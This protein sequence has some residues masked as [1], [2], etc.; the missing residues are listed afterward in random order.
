MHI[1]I[2]K[3]NSKNTGCA[4]SFSYNEEGTVWLNMIQQFSWDEK[5]GNGSFSQNA[6]NKDKSIRLKF[7]EFECGTLIRA[8]D[9]WTEAS[10]Y[11]SFEDTKTQIALTTWERGE[12]KQ[13]AFGLSVT[14]NS[15]DK[16][17][18]PIEYG[19]AIVIRTL[20]E[21]AIRRALT[22][23]VFQKENPVPQ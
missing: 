4:C 3:P 13:K 2:Y 11:H 23:N 1:A 17:K 14:R 8:I 7:N 15:A 22:K 20:L 16:F 12:K 9:T 10:F 6:K 5:S 21:S 19:E 18:L